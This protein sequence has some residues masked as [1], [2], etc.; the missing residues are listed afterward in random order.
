MKTQNKNEL[1]HY[2]ATKINKL[3][4]VCRE[5]LYVNKVVNLQEMDTFL[6]MYMLMRLNHKEIENLSRQ[7]TR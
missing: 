2:N 5:Q 3:I 1:R 4:R 6:E 7:M